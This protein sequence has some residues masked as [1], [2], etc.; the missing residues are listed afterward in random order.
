[1]QR[2]WVVLLAGCGVGC[3]FQAR[4]ALGEPPPGATSDAAIADDAAGFDA[5]QCPAAY[6]APLIPGLQTTSRYR[7]IASAAPFAVQRA[8]CEDDLPG[9]THLAVLSSQ[10]EADAIFTLVSVPHPPLVVPPSLWIGAVQR[11]IASTTDGDWIGFDDRPLLATWSTA[12]EPN[13]GD[14]SGEDGARAARKELHKEQFA[15]V[16]KDRPKLSDA[17]FDKLYGALCE[18]DGAAIP[19]RVRDEIAAN[20]PPAIAAP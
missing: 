18:C 6:D 17:S 4:P 5:T 10:A 3:G 7:V 11:R 2:L 12:S 14:T 13:D 16:Q 8:D 1:M 15:A 9:R 19:Q 20:L